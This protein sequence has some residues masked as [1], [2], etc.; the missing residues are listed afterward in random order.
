MKKVLVF[1]LTIVMV[2]S[3]AT[4]AFA[5]NSITVPDNGHDYVAYQVFTGDLHGSVL[6]NIV[7]GGGVTSEGQ[8]ALQTKYGVDSAAKLAEKITDEAAAEQFAIDVAPYLQ[9]PMTLEGTTDIEQPGYYL[10]KDASKV[11]GHDAATNYI[12][13]V[14]GS[15]TLNPKSSVPEVDKKQSKKDAEYTHDVLSAN[16]SDKVYYEITGTM[17][18]T[19]DDYTKYT[20]IFHDKLSAGLSYNNDATVTIDGKDV[21]ASFTIT[22]AEGVLT[23]SIADIKGINGVTIDADSVVVLKYT[24]TVNANAVI[25]NDG[26]TN[27]VY[28]E[29]SND[30]TVDGEG[31]TGTTPPVIV[32]VFTF[33]INANKQDN[34]NE[35]IKLEGAKFVLKNSDKS[36]YVQ[37]D[38]TFKVTGWTTDKAQATVITSDEN[39]NFNF[40]GLEAGTYFLEETVAPAGYNRLAEDVRIMIKASYDEATDKVTDLVADV[41]SIKVTGDVDEGSI[42]IVVRNSAGTTLPSTGGMGTTLIYIIGAIMMVGAG[43][44]LVTKRRMKAM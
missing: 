4:V 21:T 37:L 8:A 31:E 33:Q 7:W 12:L 11:E 15:V 9:N 14:V 25:G 2:L 23:A 22:E 5:A 1:A 41:G 32:T 43:V 44:L 19:I 30:P 13:H 27:E 3:L 10:V 40:I 39:G 17:P 29:F 24:A 38:E 42:D 36:K 26:N 16:I 18:N 20:Y 6:S 28:L 35:N 34:A